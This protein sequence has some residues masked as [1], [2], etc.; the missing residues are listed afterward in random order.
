MTLLSQPRLLAVVAV[1]ATP[2]AAYA[3]SAALEIDYAVPSGYVAG[4]QEGVVVLAPQPSNLLAKCRYAFKPPRPSSESLDAAAQA[5]LDSETVQSGM[6]RTSASQ[7]ARQGVAPAGWRYFLLG[8]EFEAQSAGGSRY[9]AIMVLAI[10][11]SPGRV[12]VVLGVGSVGGCTFD[13]VG[14]AQLFLSLNPRGW[15]NPSGNVLT[16]DLIGEWQGSRLSGHTFLADGRYF[17]SAAGVV[18]GQAIPLEGSG[19]YAV[20]G[21]QITIT[22]HAEGRPQERFRV[23][24]YDKLNNGRWQRAMSVLYDERKP[25][26]YVAEYVRAGQ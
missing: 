19:R 7:V 25:S 11:T 15:A 5:D 9:L 6:R 8:G 16:R 23:F 13:D 14:F 20:S 12:S 3:Q 18:L 22:P 17:N 26:P 21:A 4:R 10:P 24:I 2:V 1:L